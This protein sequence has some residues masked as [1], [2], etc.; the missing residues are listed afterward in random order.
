MDIDGSIKNLLQG[1]KFP[2][3]EFVRSG[4][5]FGDVYAMAAGLRAACNLPEYQGA[6]VCLASDN[7]AVMAAALLAAL[8]GGPSLLLPYS[9]SAP[10][11]ARLQQLSGFTTAIADVAREFPQGTA[12]IRPEPGNPA[13]LATATPVLPG[14]ELL[15]I[16]TG[17][18]TGAPQVWAKTRENIFGEGF[19]LFQHFQVTEKDC[20]VATVPPYHIYG[21]LFSVL[22]PLLSSATVIADTPSFPGEIVGAVLEHGATVLASIPAHYRTLH[23]RN[24]ENSS[25]RLAFS[26]AG[27]LDAE[28]N[29]AFCRQNKLGIV[30]V[31]GSTETGGIATRNRFLGETHFTPFPIVSWKIRDD[32][33]CVQSPF[34][35][36]DL[37]REDDGFFTSGDRVEAGGINGFSL[38]GRIDGVTKVGGKRVDLEEV[39]T[40]IK[41]EPGVRDCVVMALPA[42]GGRQYRLAALIQG[43]SVDVDVM[44]N[45]LA[46]SLESYALPRLIRTVQR[47]P[48]KENGKYDREAIIRLFES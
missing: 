37:T 6:A 22:L 21:L 42:S 7:K 12:V 47:I 11:L 30:E 1:P 26:S 28:D 18:T 38:L 29:E 3:R 43:T 17:G 25:L 5:T 32:R 39:R 4:A 34:L 48:L 46:D 2:D 9:F 23:G 40:I 8:V 24:L 44:R 33:I 16:F 19:N 31:Y 13:E 35:S 14:T 36:P 10:A 45:R 27:M 15:K 41:K 20:I